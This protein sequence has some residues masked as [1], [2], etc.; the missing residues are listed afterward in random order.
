MQEVILHE[1]ASEIEYYVFDHNR[2][3]GERTKIAIW[4]DVDK[5]TRWKSACLDGFA[6][7]CRREDT[8]EGVPCYRHAPG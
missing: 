6:V 3:F 5:E 4:H 2:F 7:F 8:K 1:Y